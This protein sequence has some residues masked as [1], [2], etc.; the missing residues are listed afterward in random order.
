MGPDL[1]G[2]YNPYV[3]HRSD[4]RMEC[5]IGKRVPKGK[6]DL[7]LEHRG[8]GPVFSVTETNGPAK[9]ATPSY[10]KGWDRIF[11]TAPTVGQA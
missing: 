9:V 10:R 4:C 6:G 7:S 1:G 8:P 5:G 2:G 11:G 3:R